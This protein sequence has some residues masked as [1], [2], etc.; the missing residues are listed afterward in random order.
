MAA[1]LVNWFVLSRHR[2]DRHWDVADTHDRMAIVTSY[3][4]AE[5]EVD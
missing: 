3:G 5:D 1:A 2:T 4:G